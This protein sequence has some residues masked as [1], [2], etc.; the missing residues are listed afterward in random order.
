MPAH[1]GLW[2]RPAEHVAN[3]HKRRPGGSG[4]D[5]RFD[6]LLLQCVDGLLTLLNT[7][8]SRPNA[9][10]ERPE[11]SGPHRRVRAGRTAPALPERGRPPFAVAPWPRRPDASCTTPC[12]PATPQP[13][14]P[15][16][17]DANRA[18][19]RRPCPRRNGPRNGRL[20]RC[21]HRPRYRPLSRA[22][23][24]VP[25]QPV[26]WPPPHLPPPGIRAT[27]CRTAGCAS[28]PPRERPLRSWA[29]TVRH[30]AR[31]AAARASTWP[32]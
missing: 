1:G 21:R 9:L 8:L 26:P 22:S 28:W 10:R 30:C 18:R 2:T 20:T 3:G 4:A 13:P 7:R 17:P 29:S 23:R 5:E 16:P 31:Y 24:F 15:L 32:W 11:L 6:A 12:P 25:S 14:P 19:P 27:R